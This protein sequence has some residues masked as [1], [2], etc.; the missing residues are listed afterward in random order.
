MRPLRIVFLGTP[1]FAVPSLR[2]LE[3]SPHS[4]VG[5]VTGV[6]KPRGRGQQLV[7]TPVKRFALE[8]NL[9]PILQPEKLKDPE[10]IHQ[11][12]S[13]QADLFVV[14]AFR[15]LPEAVFTI[16]PLGTINMHPSLLPKYRGA[17]PIHWTI[18]NGEKE[19]GITIIRINQRVDAGEILLQEKFPVFP[20]D[21]AGTLHDRLAEE[22]G[23]LLLDVVNRLAEGDITP[24]LQREELATPAPKITREMCHL[25]FE[26]SAEQVK[27]WIHGLSPHPAAFTYYQNDLLKFY[28]AR[29][30]DVHSQV[31]PPGTIVKAEKGEL[32]IACQPGIVAILELQKAGKKVLNTEAFLRGYRFKV[33]ERL[34]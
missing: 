31:A 8:K 6:D 11:L 34:R 23:R 24:I 1:E 25:S 26:Q 27:N 17:A 7:P 30:V 3:A 14:V 18:I 32:H 33:G 2:V 29:V 28:R 16:P 12:Q 20:E 13:L 19:T 10:F 4:V 9:S 5:V 22:G 21:T 15:I